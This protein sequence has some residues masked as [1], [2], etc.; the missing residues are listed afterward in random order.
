MAFKL[1]AVAEESIEARWRREEEERERKCRCGV[2][3]FLSFCW[4]YSGFVRVCSD[5]LQQSWACSFDQ[6]LRPMFRTA[7]SLQLYE[8]C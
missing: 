5:G 2:G 7:T 8:I 1:R 4:A 3:R 6:K